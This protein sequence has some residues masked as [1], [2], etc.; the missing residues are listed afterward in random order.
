[1]KNLPLIFSIITLVVVLLTVGCGF[2][3]HFGGKSFENALPGHMTLGIILLV[4]AICS[5]ISHFFI[6]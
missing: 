1:M 2:A 5:V 4:V 6:K 3:I